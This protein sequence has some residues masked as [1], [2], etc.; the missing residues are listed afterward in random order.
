MAA[1]KVLTP[2]AL[3]ALFAAGARADD[4]PKPQDKPAK[5]GFLGIRIAVTDDEH[6]KIM[7]VI[8]GAPA[9]KGGLKAEDIVIKMD[10]KDVKG[11]EAF[12]EAVL[13]HK[14]GDKIT[15]TVKR[16]DKE[17][18]IKITAGEAPPPDKDKDK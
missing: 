9:D 16:G 10:G 11:L 15:L 12:R 4:K 3:L 7:E 1:L 8:P 6:I 13:A 5:S 2:L 18:E 17:M 14:P